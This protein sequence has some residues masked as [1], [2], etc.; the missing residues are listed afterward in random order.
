MAHISKYSKYM[1]GEIIYCKMIYDI[2]RCI[3]PRYYCY[4]NLT[5]GICVMAI[6]LIA[7]YD[8][9]YF[10]SHQLHLVLKLST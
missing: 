7:K 2:S 4:Y 3:H 8:H 10:I 5:F 6:L 1:L 9:M